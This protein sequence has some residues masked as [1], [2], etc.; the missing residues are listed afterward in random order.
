MTLYRFDL[1]GFSRLSEELAPYEM[2]QVMAE[3]LTAMTDTVMEHQGFIDK[4]IGDAIYGVFGAP[5][6]DPEHAL[7][8]VKAAMGAR[9]RL[10][11]LNADGAA[12]LSGHRL[13]QLIEAPPAPGWEPIH[14]LESK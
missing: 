8:A 5:A 14:A 13:R 11:V 9:T 10:E 1:G 12:A 7:H 6:D 2:V 3:Y 4:N